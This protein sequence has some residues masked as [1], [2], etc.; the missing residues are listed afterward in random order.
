MERL[1]ERFE[2]A[3]IFGLRLHADQVRKGTGVPY[4]SHLMAVA[5]LV[6]ENGGNEDAVIAAFLHD[7]VEDQGGPETLEKI[8][9]LF[10][11]NVAEIVAG[12]TDAWDNPKPPWRERKEKYLK[13]LLEAPKSVLLVSVADKLHNARTIGADYRQI[14]EEV[15]SRF[16]G[17]KAGTL[18]YYQ[19]IVEAYRRTGAHQ[20]LVDELDRTVKRLV[21]AE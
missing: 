20:W 4:V 1:S 17:G 12:C 9:E 2:E 6:M 8:R 5:G 16:K 13:H 7:A 21:E 3:L 11:G 15:W 10:G 18:W 14:G 19:A